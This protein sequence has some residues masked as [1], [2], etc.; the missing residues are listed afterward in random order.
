VP[1]VQPA[2]SIDESPWRI[3]SGGEKIAPYEVE[4]ALRTHP[5]IADAVA[6]GVPDPASGEAVA[7]LVVPRGAARLDEA[8]LRR[9][10][11]DRLAPAKCPKWIRLDDAVATGPSGKVER[12]RLA[13]LFAAGRL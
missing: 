3:N 10:V 9:H 4:E 8:A 7:C 5:G 2:L 13:E 1:G 12:R 6:F 11:L